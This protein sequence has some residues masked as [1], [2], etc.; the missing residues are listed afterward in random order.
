MLGGDTQKAI[1][2]LEKGLKLGPTNALLRLRLAEAYAEA[3]RNGEAM[4]EVEVLLAAK[5]APG[6]EAEH[7]EAQ[8]EARKL[9][10]KLKQRS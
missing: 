1:G 8:E 3:N 7:N 4:K 5:P 6:Y 9:Q 10:E 2:Y